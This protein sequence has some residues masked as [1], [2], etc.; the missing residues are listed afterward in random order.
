M[1]TAPRALRTE[2]TTAFL[3]E[4]LRG[5]RRV[6]E[7]GCGRGD[8]A[9]ALAVAG[10]EVTALDLELPD[11]Q[12]AP[13]VS[14]VEADLLT[15]DPGAGAAP[16]DAVVFTASL[17]HISPLASA[18]ERAASLTAPGGLVVADDFDL[19]APDA[20]TLRWYYEVQE[21]LAAAG[22]YAADRIDPPIDPPRADL[23]ARWRDAHAHDPPLHTGAQLRRALGDR[24]SL[25]A[26][27][28]GPYLYRYIC[29]GLADDVHGAAV[30]AYL[31]EVERRGI[32]EGRLTPVGLRLLADRA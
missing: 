20:S 11:Q 25:R 7:V 12:P 18:V 17:H 19:D 8:V 26:P 28:R 6:L 13:G 4:V 24:L 14:Y 16:F 27:R 2:Q 31:L 23:V 29:G 15:F 10:H 32:S 1:P 30:A 21:L 9:R 5:R 22:A 3:L